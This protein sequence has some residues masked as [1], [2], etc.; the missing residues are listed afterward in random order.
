MRK[1]FET[2]LLELRIEGRELRKQKAR[3]ILTIVILAIVFYLIPYFFPQLSQIFALFVV[4][5]V[6]GGMYILFQ[7]IPSLYQPF[8]SELYAFKKIVR[9]IETLE[10]SS[11]PIAYEEAHRFLK[12]ALKILK[13]IELDNLDWYDEINQTLNRFLENLQLILLPAIAK[14]NIKKEHSEEIALALYSENPSKIQAVNKT[15]ESEPSYKKAKP[16]PRKIEMFTKKFRES[17]IGKLLYSLALGYG[18]VLIVC[19]IYVVATAQDFM[20]FARENPEI[21]VLG[22][23]I[24]SGITFWRTKPQSWWQS[25]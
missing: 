12:H 16:Q 4:T 25:V 6:L 10:K 14:S 20:I 23:I 11:E 17:T 2:A 18:L 7:A 13:E 1:E 22:G 21:V 15:L 5:A 19:I 3:N 8:R 9:A 24:V